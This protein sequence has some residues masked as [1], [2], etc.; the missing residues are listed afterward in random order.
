MPDAPGMEGALLAEAARLTG[1]RGGFDADAAARDLLALQ[2][3]L[4]GERSLAGAPYMEEKRRLASY[5]QFYWPVSYAQTQALLAMAGAEGKRVR[6]ILDLGSGPAPC[7]IAAADLLGAPGASIV[8]CDRSPLALESASRLAAFRGWAMETVPGWSAGNG[9]LPAGPFD[10]AVA[11]HLLNELWTDSGD[12]LERRFGLLEDALSRLAPDGLLLILEP[13]TLS[14]GR[15]TLALRDRLARSGRTILAPCVRQGPCPALAAEGQTCHSDFAWKVP[16][17]VRELSRRTG[18]GKDLVKTT[19]FV[20]AASA[21]AGRSGG[22]GA[23]AE[24]RVVSD[25]MTNKAGRVRYLICG[26]EGR[27]PLSAKR[28]EGFAAERVFFDLKRS[29]RIALS[30]PARRETGWALGG[31]TRIELRRSAAR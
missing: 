19:G 2:R 1:A 29:D 12:R 27:F 30:E 23:A 4:T 16:N 21:D 13:A 24:Y 17:A 6:R 22:V 20:A 5:L 31:S 18:L 9:T 25:P 26:A 15:E 3:G 8:A 7:S 11:G 14:A 28:G 10:L